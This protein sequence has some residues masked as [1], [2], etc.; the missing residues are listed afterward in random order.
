MPCNTIFITFDVDIVY[1]NYTIG[2][3]AIF[4]GLSSLSSSI[5]FFSVF[6][7]CRYFIPESF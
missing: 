1:K 5:L 7:S 6:I 2:K 3:L 4:L